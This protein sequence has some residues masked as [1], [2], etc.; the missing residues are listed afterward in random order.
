VSD[1]VASGIVASLAKP[2]GNVTG[3]SNF[4]P[5]TSG[6]LLELLKQTIPQLMHGAVLRDANDYGKTLEVREL[7]SAIGHSN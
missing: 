4:L 6:K 1:P 7:Q 5:T 2:V 3:V